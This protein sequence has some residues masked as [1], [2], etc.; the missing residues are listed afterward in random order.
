MKAITNESIKE[1][2][3]EIKFEYSNQ[4]YQRITGDMHFV[5]VPKKIWTLWYSDVNHSLALCNLDSYYLTV[6]S[7]EVSSKDMY[8][9][10]CRLKEALAEEFKLLEKNK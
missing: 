8:D 4:M 9:A 5:S 2:M 3:Y 1:L 6:L 10:V 7:G